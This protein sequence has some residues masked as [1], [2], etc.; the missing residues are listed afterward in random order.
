MP[1]RAYTFDA[2]L[3]LKDAGA[4][5]ASAA[6]QVGGSAKILDVGNAQFEAMLIVDVTAMDV[7]NADERYEIILQGSNSSTF[8]SGIENLAAIELGASAARRAVLRFRLSARSRLASST[9]RATPFIGICGSTPSPLAPRHRSI[10]GRAW[11]R[12]PAVEGGALT[13]AFPARGMAR[14]SYRRD[15]STGSALPNGGPGLRMYQSGRWPPAAQKQ[16]AGDQPADPL[17]GSVAGSALCAC[18]RRV[19]TNRR[20]PWINRRKRGS[21]P[22]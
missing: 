14:T 16:A 3:E 9:S 20:R 7:A 12:R 8:A 1:N 4:V 19:S 2:A 10:T 22:W 6:A 21:L 13:L 5:T 18:A 15:G 11:R 17:G